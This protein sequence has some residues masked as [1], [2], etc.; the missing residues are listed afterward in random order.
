MSFSNLV[1]RLILRLNLE[2]SIVLWILSNFVAELL[3]LFDETSASLK[4]VTASPRLESE[5]EVRLK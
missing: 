4:N 2:N 5:A 1:S 3:T